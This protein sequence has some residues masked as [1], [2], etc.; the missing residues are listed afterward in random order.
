MRL[1]VNLVA[2]SPR[3]W[4]TPSTAMPTAVRRHHQHERQDHRSGQH[5]RRG[6]PDPVRCADLCAALRPAALVDVATL[7][8]ACVVALGKYAAGVMTKDGD[9]L[10]RELLAA[11]EGFDRAWRLP[12]W[13]EYRGLLDSQFADVYNIGGRWAGAITAGCFLSH[14]TEASAGRTWTSPASP[15]ATAR[16]AW[17]RAAG[18]AA[19]AVAAGPGWMMLCGSAILARPES[20]PDRSAGQFQPRADFYLIDKAALPRG[21]AAAGVRTRAQGERCQASLLVLARDTGGAGRGAGRPA[22]VVRSRCLHAAPDRRRGREDEDEAAVL[23]APADV[24]A[25]LRPLLLNLRDA[26]PTGRVRARAGSGARRSR[27]ARSVARTLE[28]ITSRSASS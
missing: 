10:A 28:G 19:V 4:R 27:G 15:T 12:L 17:P 24:D 5:R 11:S 16:W 2:A 23:I 21:T 22:V 25:P 6:P 13:D 26:A 18:R 8:G 7:T 9:D 1:P 3:R 20:R 14:F